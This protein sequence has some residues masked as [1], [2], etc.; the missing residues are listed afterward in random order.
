[1]ETALTHN[2]NY[3]D[4][5]DKIITPILELG[6]MRINEL[7][8]SAIEINQNELEN[9][10]IEERLLLYFLGSCILYLLLVQ[11]AGTVN[12]LKFDIWP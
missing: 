5:Q 8:N 11:V 12:F 9:A 4:N 10:K 1:M 3:V 2:T 6:N 7:D